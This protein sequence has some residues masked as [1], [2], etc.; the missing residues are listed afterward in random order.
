MVPV[1]LCKSILLQMLKDAYPHNEFKFRRIRRD[2]IRNNGNWSSQSVFRNLP[3]YDCY[4][5]Y[6]F[7][8]PTLIIFFLKNNTNHMRNVISSLQTRVDEV[9]R[10]LVII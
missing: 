1:K 9:L 4:R 2:S 6:V 3:I 5:L 10:Y 7:N 8:E